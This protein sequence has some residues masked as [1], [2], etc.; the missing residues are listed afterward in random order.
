MAPFG[1]NVQ[2]LFLGGYVRGAPFLD[3]RTPL[4]GW[5]PARLAWTGGAEGVGKPGL[6]LSAGQVAASSAWAARRGNRH[7]NL[8]TASGR[9][10]S[11]RSHPHQAAG[12][13]AG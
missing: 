11:P 12:S 2:F 10:D 8:S 4:A 3:S 6:S 9:P 13:R 1:T 7:A 5:G